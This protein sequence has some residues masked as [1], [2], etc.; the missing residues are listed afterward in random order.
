MAVV[1]ILIQLPTLILSYFSIFCNIYV[2]ISASNY[3]RNL[4]RKYRH[5][6]YTD[7]DTYTD[8]TSSSRNS[9][10]GKDI[11]FVTQ[12]F[13]LAI[14]DSCYIFSFASNCIAAVFPILQ[15]NGNGIPCLLS[16]ICN[17]LF[18][19][20]SPLWHILI[21]LY[22]FYLLIFM[23][24]ND[25]IDG[26]VTQIKTRSI[27]KWFQNIIKFENFRQIFHFISI[28][29]VLFAIG[30]TILP[31]FWNNE[32]H[33]SLIYNYSTYNK[34]KD[35]YR[36]YGSECWVCGRFQIIDYVLVVLSICFHSIVVLM[37]IT[38][39]RKFTRHN[40]LFTNNININMNRNINNNNYNN[41]LTVSSSNSNSMLHKG[42]AYG[43]MVRQLLPWIVVYTLIR[44][45]PTIDRI[46]GQVSDDLVPLWLVLGHHYTIA[47]LGIA[48]A[49]VWH[50]NRKVDNSISNEMNDPLLFQ[51][52]NQDFVDFGYDY[53]QD[54]NHENGSHNGNNNNNNKSVLS[55]LTAPTVSTE[56]TQTLNGGYKASDVNK[57]V[58]GDDETRT[59]ETATRD[60]ETNEDFSVDIDIY[61]GLG[62]GNMKGRY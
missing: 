40:R 60:S 10:K 25:N 54:V 2:I 61:D 4:R 31:L 51:Q 45:L 52:S 20:L 26:K 62:G 37:A 5:G 44:V 18:G 47:S 16:G 17:Q 35:K 21:A 14:I 9:K 39:K 38:M 12:I 13:Y 27:S 8:E 41:K 7:T 43:Y 32:N 53:G 48:N 24:Q 30:A 56:M 58:I 19:T 50:S 59:L 6:T 42:G 36:Y 11:L 22:L 49:L 46:W 33:Y 29:F 15:M 3:R 57:F 23:K 28:F 1:E 55:D 34:D